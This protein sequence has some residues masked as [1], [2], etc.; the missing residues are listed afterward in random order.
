MAFI[1]SWNGSGDVDGA[2]V[3]AG[4]LARFRRELYFS[5]GLRRD[6]LF[7]VADALAC[8]QERVLM[9]A[10]LSLEPECRRGHGGVFDALNSGDVVIGRLRLALDA[11]RSRPGT[12]G[13]SGWQPMSRTGCARTRRPARSGCSA[14]RTRGGRG[15]RR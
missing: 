11:V 1:M 3:A 10:Q 5:F 2:R 13:G 6:A 8:G 7:D 4:R 15:T 9:L 14:T 12:T